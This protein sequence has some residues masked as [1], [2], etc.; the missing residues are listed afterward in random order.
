MDTVTVTCSRCNQSVPGLEDEEATAG[1]Y[2]MTKKPWSKY[3]RG[4]E[5]AVCDV[6]LQSS[7]EYQADYA[8]LPMANSMRGNEMLQHVDAA[9]KKKR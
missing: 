7:P 4:D 2:R 3:R 5:A 8:T 9:P 1:F 6:C